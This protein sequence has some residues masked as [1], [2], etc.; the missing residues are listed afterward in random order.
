MNVKE[1]KELAERWD[2]AARGSM[3][4]A[5]AAWAMYKAI[6]ALPDDPP[7]DHQDLLKMA[8]VFLSNFPDSTP[9]TPLALS[10][11]N[12][13]GKKE[14]RKAECFALM[15]GDKFQ[16]CGLKSR[17]E[18]EKFREKYYPSKDVWIARVIATEE[19]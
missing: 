14:P 2:H 5:N 12:R 13:F 4:S 6:M 15:D 16:A 7:A 18:A 9:G 19:V 1:L 10:V 17:E 8:R 3:T 11:I